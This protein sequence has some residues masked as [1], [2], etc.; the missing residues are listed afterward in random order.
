MEMLKSFGARHALVAGNVKSS[1]QYSVCY[2]EYCSSKMMILLAE[3]SLFP[4]LQR[5]QPMMKSRS[6]TSPPA[7]R[8]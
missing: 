8:E 7:A 2:W 4:L 3:T 1:R 5:K 6:P